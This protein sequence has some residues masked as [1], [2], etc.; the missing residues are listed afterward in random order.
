[1]QTLQDAKKLLK[2]GTIT[3][4]GAEYIL[5][6]GKG[7]QQIGINYAR[8]PIANTQAY[9]AIMGKQVGTI[10]KQFGSGTGLSDADREYAEKI[11]GG[12]ITLT[13]EAIEKIMAI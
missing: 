6:F 13:Q 12:K 1:L 11:V 4:A 3:G 10:I 5:A 2:S 9:A 7:L 8:D